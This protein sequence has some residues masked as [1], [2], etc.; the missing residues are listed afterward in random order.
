MSFPNLF[1]LPPLGQV[2]LRHRVVKAKRYEV[3]LVLLPPVWK[4]AGILVYFGF[5]V[6]ERRC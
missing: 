3:K 1:F 4:P 2:S 6:E 5:F